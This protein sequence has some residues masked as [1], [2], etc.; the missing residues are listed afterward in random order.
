MIKVLTITKK[1]IEIDDA[2]INLVSHDSDC[3]VAIENV[4]THQ[5][6]VILLEYELLKSN[7]IQL[8]K[9]INNFSPA[10][11]IILLGKGLQ[12]D[13]LLEYLMLGIYGYLDDNYF[14]KFIIKAI[15]AVDSGEAWISRKVVAQLIEKV[16][17]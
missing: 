4:R 12:D 14:D 10:S 1:T 7:S 9:T 13:Q 8:L 5:A 11:K 16:S 15:K 3:Q 6:R 17:A 2:N